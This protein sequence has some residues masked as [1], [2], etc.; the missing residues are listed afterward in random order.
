VIGAYEDLGMQIT[1]TRYEFG[2]AD[3]YQRTLPLRLV[4][5]IS[6]RFLGFVSIPLIE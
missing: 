5:R 6:F 1:G 2:H 4:I 3:D